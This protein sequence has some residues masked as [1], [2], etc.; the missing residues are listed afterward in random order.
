MNSST[1]WTIETKEN[2]FHTE[3]LNELLSPI[4][5][6]PPE[7]C[8]SAAGLT[9]QAARGVGTMREP[10][11]GLPE[12]GDDQGEEESADEEGRKFISMRR[13]SE[14]V[15]HSS[16]NVRFYSLPESVDPE[17]RAR[18]D[19][20]HRLL[21]LPRRRS[22]PMGERQLLRRNQVDKTSCS[23]NNSASELCHMVEA[24]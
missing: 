1:V 15:V 16:N 6:R 7:Q 20:L 18:L 5:M 4:S 17:H 19:E 21:T 9:A 14:P 24:S 8:I 23:S 10:L 3:S 11:E 12:L 2:V 22:L 13:H